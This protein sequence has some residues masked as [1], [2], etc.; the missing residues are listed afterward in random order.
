MAD[1]PRLILPDPVPVHPK[2]DG[3]AEIGRGE[4]T[5]VLEGD[6]I[7]GQPHVLKV[8]SSPTDYAYYTAADRPTG[9]HFPVVYADLGEA[10]R[11]SRG[12]PF[13]IVEVEKLYP[14][15]LY[16]DT[17]ELASK[18]C[19]SYLAA[20]K[21]WHTFA[22]D[23]GRIALYHL[24]VTPMGWTDAMLESLQ[25]LQNFINEYSALPDL[26]KADNLM[27]RRDGTLVFSDP[28]FMG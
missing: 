2:L 27:M 8:L 14:L 15:P 4:H 5:I 11:S 1:D 13:H 19:T 7:N 3:R 21:M 9:A 20:C 12:Y 10:G 24:T 25:A 28:V 6:V 26:I 17:A 16:G 22:Q 23:M 18:L